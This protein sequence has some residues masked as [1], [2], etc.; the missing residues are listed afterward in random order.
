MRGEAL[1]MVETKGL[2][3]AIEAADAMVKAANVILVG[4][5]KIGSGL[6]TVLVRGDVGAVKAATDTG[7]A[8]AQRVGELISVHVIPRPHTDIEKILPKIDESL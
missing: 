1:G 5:E 3:G 4:Y 6:V 7:A 8:A 2:V